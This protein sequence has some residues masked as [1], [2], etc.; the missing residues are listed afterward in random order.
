MYTLFKKGNRKDVNNNS[1]I[2]IMNSM[3]KVYAMIMFT[4]K[5]VTQSFPR[6]SWSTGEERMLRTHC[7]S[8][9]VM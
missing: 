2:S 1:G 8:T 4:T 6:T 5:D 7:V 9:V 3:A